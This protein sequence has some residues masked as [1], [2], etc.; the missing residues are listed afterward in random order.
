MTTGVGERRVDYG[1]QLE[2]GQQSGQRA[3]QLLQGYR[4][5]LGQPQRAPERS[6]VERHCNVVGRR[7]NV[8][9]RRCTVVGQNCN[10][11]GRDCSGIVGARSEVL[12]C[13]HGLQ[14]KRRSGRL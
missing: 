3:L 5:D 7:C 8:V 4:W 10:G 1:Q 2:H 9:G 14:R 13:A 6:A 12:R 11:R